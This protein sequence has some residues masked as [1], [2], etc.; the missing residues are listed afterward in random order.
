MR[1]ISELNEALHAKRP[2]AVLRK[3]QERFMKM[4]ASFSAAV[5]RSLSLR[6]TRFET[7]SGKLD[8]I[9]PRAVLKRGF[10]LTQSADGNVLRS[11]KDVKDGQELTTVLA[12]GTIKSRVECTT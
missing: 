2:H 1:Y 9:G 12:D 5:T 11:S 4:E 10:S 7:I 8:A 3:R 6:M